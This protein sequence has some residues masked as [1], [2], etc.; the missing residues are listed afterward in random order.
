[1]KGLN[2]LF[3]HGLID[4]KPV[5]LSFCENCVYGKKARHPFP[6][7]VYIAKFPL[8]YVHSDFWGPAQ[9][10]TVG[11]KRYFISFIDHFSR[12]LWVYLLRTKD[13]AFDTFK[14]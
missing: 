12:K 7:S 5:D 14:H 2:Y 11:G 6:K 4:K 3:K 10:E 1:M 8:E 9:V 13:E